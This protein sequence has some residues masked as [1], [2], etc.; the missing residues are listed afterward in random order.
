M[1]FM[2][3]LKAVQRV[4]AE[5][6]QYIR[7]FVIS[8]KR[9]MRDEH[10]GNR[11]DRAESVRATDQ[12]GSGNTENAEYDRKGSTEVS[13]TGTNT[14]IWRSGSDSE[15]EK[16][17]GENDSQL[18]D[19]KLSRTDASYGVQREVG[20]PLGSKDSA[21][22]GAVRYDA[23]KSSGKDEGS[24][25][26]FS[27]ESVGGTEN[28]GADYGSNKQG[29]SLQTTDNL[30][31]DK[32]IS[33]NESGQIDLFTYLTSKSEDNEAVGNIDLSQSTKKKLFSPKGRISNEVI[34]LILQS[35][36]AG[37][38]HHAIYEVFN[39]YSTRWNMGNSEWEIEEINAAI[40]KIKQAYGGAALGF[41][42]DGKRISV[43]YDKEQGMLLAYGDECRQHPTEIISWSDVEEHI[44]DMVESN[45]FLDAEEEIIAA[46]V[47]EEEV[48]TDIVYYF[49]DAFDVPKERL[50]EPFDKNG[51]IFPNITETVRQVIK[52]HESGSIL[53]NHAK[54]LWN[55][56]ENGKIDCHWKYACKSDRV[57]HLEAY[58]NGRYKFQL[59]SHIDKLVPTF[60]PNDAIDQAIHLKGIT[61]SDVLFRR[62]LFDT[63]EMGKDMSSV[64]EYLKIDLELEDMGILDLEL[65]M[66]R[67]KDIQLKLIQEIKFL[68]NER[69]HIKKLQDV[70]VIILKRM[71]CF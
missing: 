7:D 66:R 3:C 28:Q 26:E 48:V 12:N 30:E 35:G 19:G 55:E 32:R 5:E 18:S 14:S 40:E 49:Q 43:Y 57:D 34:D 68:W 46:Q 58:L 27:R 37:Y 51:Y 64:V 62:E 4:S 61:E 22:N 25:N 69:F 1:L 63:S 60:I 59:P 44:Y 67:V 29:N 31:S 53:L 9:R 20:D 16:F 56:Y 6:L 33:A 45:H 65:I 24:D 21:G 71:N 10:V 70:F 42:V 41:L 36:P 2:K 13:G 17:L 23:E 52:N 8:E 11:G 50:P 54:Q 39:Y 15:Q 47:D 38:N